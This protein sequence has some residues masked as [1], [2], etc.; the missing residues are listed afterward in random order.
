MAFCDGSVHVISFFIDP[1]THQRLANRRDGQA[2]DAS[3]Y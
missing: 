2:I 1:T 3:K